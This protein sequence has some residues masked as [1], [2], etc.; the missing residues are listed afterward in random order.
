MCTKLFIITKDSAI[1][2][3]SKP[4]PQCSLLAVGIFHVSVYILWV[5]E[6]LNGFGRKFEY[7]ERIKFTV[8]FPNPLQERQCNNMFYLL[9]INVL[10]IRGMLEK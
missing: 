7:S 3:C 10:R 2:I 5:Y 8:L 1:E 9:M 4:L 6:L